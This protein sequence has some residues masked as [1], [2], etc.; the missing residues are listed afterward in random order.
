M[1]QLLTLWA[2]LID[3]VSPTLRRRMLEL[4]PVVRRRMLLQHDM[5]LDLRVHEQQSANESGHYEIICV[6]KCLD[7]LSPGGVCLDIGANIGFYAC[8]MAKKL[9][10]AESGGM[11]YAFEPLT[12]NALRL[13]QN[14][15]LNRLEHYIRIIRF[16]L[17]SQPGRI[18]LFRKPE[19][20][21]NNAVGRNMMSKADLENITKAGWLSERVPVMRLDDWAQKTG[22]HRCDLIKI[23]IEGAE[24]LVFQGARKLLEQ[25]RPAIVGEF[26]PYWMRQIGQSFEDVMAFF[27]PLGY[28][29]FRE[30]NGQFLRVTPQ[31]IARDLEVPN[32]LLL[33]N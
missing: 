20:S 32:Y 9:A 11:I 3:I 4:Y 10:E 25:F 33:P 21:A 1:M 19:G 26:S 27:D 14:I 5:F 12:R 23:D 31:R 28:S 29:Y 2:N 22:L 13:R 8:A 24:L 15:K 18:D 30:I 6:R 17:G 16:A 7:L